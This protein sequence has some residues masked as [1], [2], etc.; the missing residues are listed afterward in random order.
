MKLLGNRVTGTV[1]ESSTKRCD[2][3]SEDAMR[4]G[5]RGSYDYRSSEGVR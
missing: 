5:K 3:K 4:K 2:L 1:R